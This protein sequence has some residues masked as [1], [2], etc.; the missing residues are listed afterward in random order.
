MPRA[1]VVMVAFTWFAFL[2]DWKQTSNKIKK[3][4]DLLLAYG[5]NIEGMSGRYTG[6]HN[7]NFLRGPVFF[8]A[9][10]RTPISDDQIV[11]SPSWKANLRK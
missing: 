3:Y 7:T 6:Y 2:I 1:L 8:E 10:F 9:L 5:K 4:D 11:I